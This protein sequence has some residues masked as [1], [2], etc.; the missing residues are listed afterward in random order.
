MKAF[1]IKE[2]FQK[3]NYYTIHYPPPPPFP[4]CFLLRI[5]TD[6][7]CAVSSVYM[8]IKFLLKGQCHEI[9]DHF[10]GL[11]DSTWGL[12]EQMKMVSPNFSFLR[13]DLWKTCRTVGVG[14][15]S[16]DL[17]TFEKRWRLLTDF[18]GTIRQKNYLDVLQI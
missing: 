12:Y 7:Q 3:L 9:F 5:L 18:K 4:T 10:F 1:N 2:V 16:D 13:R 6:V 15:V 11:K 8:K 17:D 14:I